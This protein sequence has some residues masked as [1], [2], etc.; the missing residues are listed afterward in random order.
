MAADELAKLQN[1]AHRRAHN[2]MAWCREK[3]FHPR[4]HAI[5]EPAPDGGEQLRLV[6]ERCYVTEM[7]SRLLR[8]QD[9]FEVVKP[10][11][12]AILIRQYATAIAAS[13]SENR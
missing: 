4:Q 6:V 3:P 1:A 13:H 11:E 8:L 7:A 10:V 2:W 5:M 9:C 12:L